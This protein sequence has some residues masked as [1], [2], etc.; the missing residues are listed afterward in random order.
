MGNLTEELTELL[1]SSSFMTLATSDSSGQP[2]ATP[3]EFAC[4]EVPRFY[5]VSLI[6]A[7][8]S[9]NVRANPHAALVIYDST[10]AP[11]VHAEV[12]GLYAEGS[13]EELSGADLEEV[14]PSLHRWTGLRHATRTA[15]VSSSRAGAEGSDPSAEAGRWRHY[16][17]TPVQ[18]YALDPD[19]HP[20]IPGVRVWRARVDLTDSF[21]RAHRSRLT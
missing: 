15:A 16:R 14:L 12:Q 4:D 19:G 8:H 13:V 21:S 20:D 2:W 6:D 17:L 9:Q 18:L 10:Q 1:F 7:R 11:G 5:W 3:V